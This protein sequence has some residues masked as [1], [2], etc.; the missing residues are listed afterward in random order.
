MQGRL[1][2]QPEAAP[3]PLP[4]LATKNVTIR[5]LIESGCIASGEQ[6]GAK[7]ATAIL[8]SPSH[9]NRA[10][11]TAQGGF[12]HGYISSSHSH[13]YQWRVRHVRNS[14]RLLAQGEAAKSLG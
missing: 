11:A 12:K 2:S 10:Q 1:V 13:S 3:E 7:M 6:T 5:H 8:I 14:R 4:T 9:R